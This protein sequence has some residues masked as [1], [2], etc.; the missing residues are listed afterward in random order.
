MT[1]EQVMH[2]SRTSD[3][4]TTSGI[5]LCGITDGRLTH[6]KQTVNCPNCR[7]ILN[8]TRQQYPQHAGFSDWR[9]TSDQRRQAARD[10]V[11]DMNGGADD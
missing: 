6:P 8:H 11:A 1:K 2:A 10:F 9:L 7:V 4:D 3:S 5:A